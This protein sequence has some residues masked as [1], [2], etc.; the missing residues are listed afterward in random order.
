MLSDEVTQKMLSQIPMKTY[1]DPVNVAN[2]VLFLVSDVAKYVTGQ[3]V[4]VD[5]GMLM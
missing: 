5:G 4:C 1:G 2:T 3:V